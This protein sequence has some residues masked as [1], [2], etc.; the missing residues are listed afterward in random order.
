MALVAAEG[1]EP[2]T[3]PATGFDLVVNMA[4]QA[5]YRFAALSFLDPRRGSW[6]RLSALRGDATLLSGAALLRSLSEAQP[7][8]YGLGESPIE[9]LD[10]MLVLNR[11]PNS[12]RELNAQY[13]STFGLLVSSNCPPYET[14]YINSKFTY[15]RSHALADISGFYQAFGLAPSQGNPERP[16][17]V[18]LELEFMASLLGLER[19]AA[20]GDAKR[21][22]DRQQICRDAQARFLQ[23]HLA[24][25]VPSFVQLLNCADRGPFYAAAGAFLV[26]LIPAERAILG[27]APASQPVGPN[28]IERPESC[29][30]CGSSG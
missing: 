3:N 13:E 11:F 2:R 5:M 14:E 18:V 26:A 19:L 17:H 15:Q 6:E 10:P 21:R 16:D 25:W 8:E 4:R 23:E 9:M 22:H 29:E 28:T 20:D 24:W 7:R 1:S 27:V 12:D 30:G